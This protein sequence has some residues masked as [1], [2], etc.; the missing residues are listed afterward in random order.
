M[1]LPCPE[2]QTRRELVEVRVQI[3]ENGCDFSGVP[4]WVILLIPVA[5]V[6]LKRWGWAVV[7][8]LGQVA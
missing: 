2:A 6:Q 8:G 7:W 1:R 3:E 5:W 4:G